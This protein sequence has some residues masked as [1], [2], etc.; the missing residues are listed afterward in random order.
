MLLGI[1][2]GTNICVPHTLEPH[3][4]PPPQSISS[5]SNPIHGHE[6][7]RKS[8]ALF[9]CGRKTISLTLKMIEKETFFAFFWPHPGSTNTLLGMHAVSSKALYSWGTRFSLL[10]NNNDSIGKELSFSFHAFATP[11]LVEPWTMIRASRQCHM[12]CHH[13]Q[14]YQ[15]Q[16]CSY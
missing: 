13:Y 1:R 14:E 16:Y 4:Y 10:Y 2:G 11:G 12:K 5:F 15:Y 3:L 8:P 9:Q 6:N 7:A